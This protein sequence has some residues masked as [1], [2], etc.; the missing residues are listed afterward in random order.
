[1]LE[2][3]KESCWGKEFCYDIDRSSRPDLLN[4]V[5][6]PSAV[7]WGCCMAKHDPTIGTLTAESRVEG[8]AGRRRVRA[9]TGR[10]KLEPSRIYECAVKPEGEDATAIYAGARHSCLEKPERFEVAVKKMLRCSRHYLRSL[11]W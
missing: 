3:C 4:E 2:L 6:D 7:L 1:M 11:R 5:F 8:R 10:F 9:I